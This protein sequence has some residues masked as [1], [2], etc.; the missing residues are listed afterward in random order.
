MAI[1]WYIHYN[2]V[3]QLGNVTVH[4]YSGQQLINCRV[5]KRSQKWPCSHVMLI[6]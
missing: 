1:K 2:Y 6:L 5:V 3:I 4:V